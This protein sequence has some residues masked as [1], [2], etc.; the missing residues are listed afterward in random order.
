MPPKQSLIKKI[1]SLDTKYKM[2]QKQKHAEEDVFQ[3]SPSFDEPVNYR[4]QLNNK[5]RCEI[6]KVNTTLVVYVVLL[7]LN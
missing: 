3:K 2:G 7:P 6:K 5:L 4:E 1:N